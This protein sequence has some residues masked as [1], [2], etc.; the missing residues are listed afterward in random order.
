MKTERVVFGT[1]LFEDWDDIRLF[2]SRDTRSISRIENSNHYV[3]GLPNQQALPKNWFVTQDYDASP[4]QPMLSPHFI[5]Y[6]GK[7]LISASHQASV[8]KFTSIVP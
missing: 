4:I 8:V 3:S 2:F 7:T 5:S 1:W 6:M